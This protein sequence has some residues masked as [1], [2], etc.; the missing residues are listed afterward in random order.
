MGA[1][2]KN[3]FTYILQCSNS[4]YYCGVT[5]DLKKRVL[6]HNEGKGSKYVAAHLPAELIW[7]K[8]MKSNSTAQVLE[9]KIKK[10]S[11]SNKEKFMK[12]LIYK[13]L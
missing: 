5:N 13:E 2:S 9:C 8:K 12:G 10:W 11:R 3:W 6:H 7:S 1:I 4:H